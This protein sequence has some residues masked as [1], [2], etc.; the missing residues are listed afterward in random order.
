MSSGGKRKPVV[1]FLCVHNSC[2]S[3]MAEGIARNVFGDAVIALSAGSERGRSVNAN[4]V[5]VMKEIGLFAYIQ[6]HG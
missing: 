2:R 1:V 5:A 6:A 3:Q 4:T